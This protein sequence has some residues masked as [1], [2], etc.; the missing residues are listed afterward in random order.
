MALNALLKAE[1]KQ[2]TNFKI[3]SREEKVLC[4]QNID[5]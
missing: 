3:N 5:Y 2:K 1:L 4:D